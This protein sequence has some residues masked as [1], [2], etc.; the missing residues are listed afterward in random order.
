MMEK[1]GRETRAGAEHEPAA[2]EMPGPGANAPRGSCLARIGWAAWLL[3]VIF[4]LQNALASRLEGEFRAA[5]IFWFL[6]FLL[7]LGGAIIYIVRRFELDADPSGADDG[8][9]SGES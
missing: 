1:P 9:L 7:I 6:F 4:I 8:T 5:A 2:V 3:A